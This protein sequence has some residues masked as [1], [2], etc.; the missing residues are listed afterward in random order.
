MPALRPRRTAVALTLAFLTLPLMPTVATASPAAAS[1]VAAKPSKP[2][3]IV[4]DC[5]TAQVR[6]TEIIL[7]CY[8]GEVSFNV[9]KWK[10]YGPKV[11]VARGTWE[12]YE[13]KVAVAPGKR[14][15]QTVTATA[16]FSKP[17]TLNSLQVHGRVFTQLRIDPG[18]RGGDDGW[19]YPFLAD[20]A[21]CCGWSW[22]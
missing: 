15:R 20:S 9:T 1:S 3:R 19:T 10:R 18:A 16:T 2:V 8:D 4:G 12:R 6:P 5:Q 14:Q 22:G 17:R 21:A 11:A 7:D 13:Q